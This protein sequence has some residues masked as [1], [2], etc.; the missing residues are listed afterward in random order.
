MIYVYAPDGSTLDREVAELPAEHWVQT[1]ADPP[2]GQYVALTEGNADDYGYHPLTEVARPS[3]DHVRTVELVGGVWSEVWTFSQEAEDARLAAEDRETKRTNVANAVATLR[4]W[5][6]DAEATTATSGNAV[7][8]L[9]S[10]VDRLG[11]L[12]D[13][14]ADIAQSRSL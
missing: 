4:Q 8:V 14:L 7:A 12:C 10:V 11:I 9:N 1:H 5:A 3:V 2:A 6:R 13:R